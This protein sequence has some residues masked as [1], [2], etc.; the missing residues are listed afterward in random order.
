MIAS[1]ATSTYFQ[2]LAGLPTLKHIRNTVI[3][4]LCAIAGARTDS[5][6]HHLA[7][8]SSGQLFPSKAACL[9]DPR[10][11]VIDWRR[12]PRQI[13]LPF[14]FSKPSCSTY[15]NAKKE[16]RIPNALDFPNLRIQS[17]KSQI[18]WIHDG[19]YLYQIHSLQH[20]CRM[21]QT[22]RNTGVVTRLCSCQMTVNSLI[23]KAWIATAN[24]YIASSSEMRCHAP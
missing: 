12:H 11:P 1:K 15:L 17:W 9:S 22:Y 18:F 8:T 14:C 16:L 5:R 19:R 7:R 6:A 21:L 10:R 24:L 23:E 4:H 2:Q 13:L 3:A 20:I